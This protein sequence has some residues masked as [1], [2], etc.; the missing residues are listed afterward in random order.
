VGLHVSRRQCIPAAVFARLRHPPAGA[1]LEGDRYCWEPPRP[2]LGDLV[3]A[4]LSAVGITPERVSAVTGRPCGCKERQ[5][6][7]N[8][9]GRRFG[10]G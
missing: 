9:L 5:A 6:K 10:I 4:G 7:L 3:A 8:D 1:V 2:G